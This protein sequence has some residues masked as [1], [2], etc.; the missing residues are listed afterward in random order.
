MSTDPRSNLAGLAA[1]QAETLGSPEICV[2][3][4][5]GPVDLAH[6]AFRGANVKA[7]EMPVSS[8]DVV[9]RAHGT[10]VASLV[11]GQPGGPLP[12][13]APHTR[14]IIVPVHAFRPYQAGTRA[15]GR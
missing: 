1:L 5:D 15:R 4:L 13:I 9:D 2:A 7:L 8:D 12:G 6:A 3:V 14:G 11:F 10:H